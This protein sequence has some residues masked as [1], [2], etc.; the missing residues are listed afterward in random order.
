MQRATTRTWP[1]WLTT[2]DA[3]GMQGKPHR[4]VVHHLATTHGLS[5]WW[6]QMVCVGYEQAKGQRVP[7]EKARGFEVSVTRTLEASAS[8]VFRA[9]NDPTRRGWCHVQ[10]YVV[11]TTIAPR[12]L[13][14][15]FSDGTLVAVAIER[16]G[17]TRCAVSVQH[18]GLADEAAA[19]RARAEWKESLARLAQALAE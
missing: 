7:N 4:D 2:L 5:S 3:E 17:N 6:A 8:E 15:G 9:F 1:E 11:R 13:R 18:A 14:L 16:K 12:S 10:D 19:E